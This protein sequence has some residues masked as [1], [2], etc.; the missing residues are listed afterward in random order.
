MAVLI[1]LVALAL[2]YYLL[3]LLYDRHWDKGLSCELSFRDDYAFEDDTSV[4]NEVLINDKRLP[5]PVVEI[6][7]H[8]DKRLRFD[9]G[10]NASVSDRSYRRDVFALS[11][12]QKITRSLEF[13]CTG[14]G[15]FHIDE[16]GIM[17]QDLFLTQKYRL[18]LPQSTEFYVLPKPVP[19]QQI[20]IPFSRIMGT[21][22]S[23]KKIYD[24]PFEFAGLREYS[25]SDPMKYIN[26]KATA[27][28]GEMLVNLH[29]S[30]LS[31]RVVVLLDMEGRANLLN[32]DSVRIACSL[33]ERLLREGVQLD[34]YSN[35]TDT[36]TGERWKLES[37][38][39][40]G[41]MLFLK[42]R[43]A[44]VAA[45]DNLPKICDCVPPINGEEDLLVLVSRSQR[46]D[47]TDE[48][49]A[50][51]GKSHGVQVIPWR[52]EHKELEIARNIDAVW[53]EM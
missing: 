4:L 52:A 17:A 20:S 40:E 48:F 22:L 28:T 1:I 49:S 35:G 6:D 19:T 36:L 9:D 26:W 47:N 34:I 46:Q 45:D 39:G 42:K 18:S 12:R 38:S 16:V 5:M 27:R 10:Q 53:L 23:R 29:E 37:V 25:R 11:V 15:C 2:L 31:Q 33:C 7:F 21:V 13:K 8:M 30:T 50:L 41:S 24:D 44:C 43:F 32:E 3:R 51:V 14:R